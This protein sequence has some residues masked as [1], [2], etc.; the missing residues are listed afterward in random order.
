MLRRLMRGGMMATMASMAWRNRGAIEQ[1][2]RSM[3]NQGPD[4][5]GNRRR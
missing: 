1:K 5:A 3:T 2:V 4:R